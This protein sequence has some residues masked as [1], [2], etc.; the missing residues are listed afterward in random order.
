MSRVEHK[1]QLINEI[2]DTIVQKY[3]AVKSIK[4]IS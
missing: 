2:K 1:V 4:L 3:I